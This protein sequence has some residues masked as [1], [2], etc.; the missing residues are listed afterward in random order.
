[1]KSI[2]DLRKI[3][4]STRAK[5]NIESDASGDTIRVAVG[6]ATCGMAAGAKPV[7]AAFRDEVA[8]RGLKNINVI[9]TGCIGVCRLEPIVE[10]YIPGEEK[11]TYV[12]MTPD[13]VSPII[14][15]H[16]VNH[17]VITEY[18]IGAAE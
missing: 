2:E 3:R 9:Q 16:L 5:M 10:V 11:V 17:Q 13:K 4:E 15:R 6:L 1:M 18:T 14:T 12:K 8:G 7:F